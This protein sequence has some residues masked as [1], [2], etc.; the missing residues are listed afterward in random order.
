MLPIILLT[1]DLDS[2]RALAAVPATQMP[3][4]ILGQLL[5]SRERPRLVEPLPD[6]EPRQLPTFQQA[7]IQVRQVV[8][9][10]SWKLG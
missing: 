2:A 3:T 1:T 5:N 7:P 10:V 9:A 6:L 4:Q 8:R